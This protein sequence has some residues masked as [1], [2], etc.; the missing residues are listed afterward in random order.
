MKN[1]KEYMKE[2]VGTENSVKF[3][4]ISA[5]QELVAQTNILIEQI[6]D[7][8]ITITGS[9]DVIG[10]VML[11]IGEASDKIDAARI[12]MMDLTI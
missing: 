10:D 5:L 7:D 11:T 4:I 3:N 8:A 2:D 9:E 6:E 1:F 12:D